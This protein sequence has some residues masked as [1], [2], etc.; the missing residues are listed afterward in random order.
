MPDILDA[1]QTNAQKAI[2]DAAKSAGVPPASPPPAEGSAPPTQASPVTSPSAP[3]EAIAQMPKPVA[4]PPE[5][6]AAAAPPP[7]AVEA[8]NAQA[9]LPGEPEPTPETKEAPQETP[10]QRTATEQKEEKV[11]DEILNVPEEPAAAA[12]P[13]PQGPKPKKSKSIRGVVLA[14][15]ALLLFTIPVAVYYVS[16]QNRR[17]AELRSSAVYDCTEDGDIPTASK[18]CCSGLNLVN[19]RCR[20]GGG[21]VPTPTPTPRPTCTQQGNTCVPSRTECTDGGGAVVSGACSSGI[22][23]SGLPKATP[24]PPPSKGPDCGGASAGQSCTTGADCH[25][26]GGDACTSKK[27]EPDIRTSCGNQNRAWCKNFNDPSGYTCCVKGYVCGPNNN[28]CVPG[29]GGGGGGETPACNGVKIYKDGVLVPDPSSLQ[30]NDSIV[31]AVSGGLATK[32]HIRINGGAWTETSAKNASN[33]YT[34]DFTITPASLVDN[35]ISIE[36][37]IYGTDGKWH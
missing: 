35:K 14:V 6:S 12:P 32:A 7:V 2:D 11:V 18:P 1:A 24:T 25:C 33:E 37:E 17:V 20:V 15:L 21:I 5:L 27:C 23:C 31:I 36:A 19:G 29:G 34:L 3:T 10:D 28:G 13:P 9:P 22:C 30:I 4:G 16:E 8:S 26:Q